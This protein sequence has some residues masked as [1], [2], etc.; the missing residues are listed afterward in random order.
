ML[1]QEVIEHLKNNDAV[2]ARNLTQDI[3]NA[4][5]TELLA[6][7]YD[8]IAPTVFGEA[9]KAPKTDKEDDGEGMDPVGHGDSDIDNDG[10]SDDSDDYLKNRRKVISKAVKTEELDMDEAVTTTLKFKNDADGA[11][12]VG[13]E[14]SRK[15]L[16]HGGK[17]VKKGEYKLTFK[18][19]KQMMQFMDKYSEKITE[20]ISGKSAGRFRGGD[21]TY[22]VPS[23]TFRSASPDEKARIKQKHYQ[24]KEKETRDREMKRK[25]EV[26]K[27][28]ASKRE[29]GQER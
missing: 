7:K 29:R 27:R 15:G 20:A 3:L 14:T 8:E 24:D 16:L 6:D 23:Q 13:S 9:K 21:Q 4:K 25:R 28:E 22:G 19:D 5:M 10:D 12:A 11:A 2:K 18:N 1:T 17:K 26:R